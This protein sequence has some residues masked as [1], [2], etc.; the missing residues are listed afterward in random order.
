MSGLGPVRVT[1]SPLGRRNPTVKLALLLVVSV[2][3]I[4]V[5]DP[6]TPLALYLAS[7]AA[8][9]WWGRIR[10]RTLALAHIPFAAFAFGMFTVN[11]L[12]RPGEVLWQEGFL[13]ITSE[14]LSIGAALGL[15]TLA[16]GVLAIGFVLS[17]DSMRL[18]TS[19][20]QQARLGARPTYAIMSGYR[21]LEQ[22]GAEWVTIR[23]A[24]AVRAP[25]RAG[26]RADRGPR[27]FGRAAFALLVVAVRRGE[28]VAQAL[29]SRGLG[30]EPRTV[31]QPVAV[32]RS[33]FVM[34]GLTMAVLAVTLGTSA[35]LGVLRGPGA[36]F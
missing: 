4:F 10:P 16:I 1:D 25:L 22:L 31:W 36:M 32:S 8:V 24:Q 18:M 9:W 2:A 6:L 30:L 11:A 14:G 5:L 29:E 12:S 17:T 13:R 7:L 34:V 26:R 20:H 21:L 27:A 3:L 19:L 33:D 35:A 15:R 28:Q 23:R